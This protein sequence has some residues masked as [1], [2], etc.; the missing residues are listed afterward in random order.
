MTTKKCLTIF[1][2]L[3]LLG[4]TL[5]VNS[6]SAAGNTYYVSS[7]SGNDANS[8]LTPGQPL[9]S[10]AAVNALNL[11]PGDSVRFFCGETWR[12]T[13]LTIKDSGLDGNQIVIGSYPEGCTNK[14]V[15][16]GAQPVS[17]WYQ[18]SGNLYAAN[19]NNG[20]NAGLFGLGVNQVF[21]GS[22]RL[23]LGRW[24]NLGTADGGYSTI[25]SYADKKITDSALPGG[26]WNGASVHIR[27]MRWYILN[28]EV[29]GTSGTTLTLNENPVCWG[30]S[31]TGW[32]FFINN[33]LNTL[34]QNGEWYYDSASGI[35]YL[36][37]TGGQPADGSIEAS[38]IVKDEEEGR[39]WGGINLGR[40]LNYAG[41]HHVTVENLTVQRWYKNGISMPTNYAHQEGHH[42]ILRNN[43]IRDVDAIGISLAVWVYEAQDGRPSDWRGGY[44]VTV[45]DNLIERA[46]WKGIDTYSRESNFL[47][48]TIR[49]IG[50][51]ENL[52]ASGLGCGIDKDGGQCTEDGDG[53]RLKLGKPADTAHSNLIQGNLIDKTAYNGMDIFGHTNTI[54]QNVFLDTCYVKGDCGAVRTFGRDNLTATNVY[55]LVFEENVINNVIGNTDGCRDDF[56]ALFGFGFYIDNYSRNI[57]INQNTVTGA[58]V[59]GVLY[60][61]S[62]GQMYGNVLYGNSR[63]YPYNGAQVYLTGSPTYLA[64]FQNNTMYALRSGAYTLG[65]PSTSVLG[66]SDHN[67]YFNPYN[68]RSISFSGGKTLAEWQAASGKD[69]NSTEAW[70]SLTDGDDPLSTLFVNQESTGQTIN[71]GDLAYLDLD[72]QD[73][74]HSFYL[75][76]YHSKI[77]VNNGMAPLT[78]LSVYPNMVLTGSADMTLSIQG[79]GYTAQSV[80]RVDGTDISTSFVDSQHLTAV[81]PAALL[82]AV[83]QLAITVYDPADGGFETTGLS[84][85]V[86]EEIHPV[87]LP[88]ITR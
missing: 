1:L 30:G 25:D 42:I 75:A 73:Y 57:T 37:T 13:P 52:G 9:A 21:S 76:P 80:V 87:Y 43:I 38:V 33:H 72:Q 82:T 65:L 63:T 35:L 40:D 70:F 10:V 3:V 32:G 86:V 78:I 28:R 56:D 84:L 14:P 60:Q 18:V 26:N 16:S 7:V 39:A 83:D 19:L 41:I 22:T 79:T 46:N 27:G 45:E 67:Y 55:D 66:S 47:N 12:G 15:L 8:G 17:G 49:D 62:T 58:T 6:T 29:T 44:A 53:F 85:Y 2:I 23:L 20:A 74:Y 59:H 71:L 11:Q 31:C 68:Q 50:L 64:S 36:Y 61:R 77:L 34:D 54:K 69:A 81:V 51:V 5:P 24:P 48:N 4:L 88:L